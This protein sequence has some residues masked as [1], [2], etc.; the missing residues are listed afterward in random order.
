[1]KRLYFLVPNIETASLVSKQ[2]QEKGVPESNIYTIGK[3]H[4]K[5]KAANLHHAGILQTT[6]FLR[7]FIRGVLI[8]GLAGALAGILAVFYLP[9][10]LELGHGTVIAF[11]VFGLGFGSWVSTLIGVSVIKPNIVK[12]EKALDE[13]NLLMLVD[14][15]KVKEEEIISLIKVY[16]PEAIVEGVPLSPKSSS[17]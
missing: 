17:K 12:F 15:P 8:G 9:R 14:I 3:E 6:D 7:A 1:M 11:A 13:G 16:H 5:F 2:L 4:H 10:D